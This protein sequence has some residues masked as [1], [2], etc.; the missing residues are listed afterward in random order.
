MC[1]GKTV[2]KTSS[3]FHF[4]IAVWLWLIEF[5]SWRCDVLHYNFIRY[6]YDDRWSPVNAMQRNSGYTIYINFFYYTP[7][8]AGSP[9][10]HRRC[11]F[12]DFVLGFSM[13]YTFC[14]RVEKRED[15]YKCSEVE[16][17]CDNLLC[18]WNRKGL[19]E[20]RGTRLYH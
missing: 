5:E 17:F 8:L 18:S 16:G 11:R 15:H 12:N 4:T 13:L 1:V 9:D 7:G 10:R 6:Y 3:C 2:K 14:V 19:E 20:L